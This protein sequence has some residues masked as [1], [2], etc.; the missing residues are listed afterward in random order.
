MMIDTENLKMIKNLC[1][2]EVL[3]IYIEKMECVEKK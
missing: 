1:K 3:L 2:K